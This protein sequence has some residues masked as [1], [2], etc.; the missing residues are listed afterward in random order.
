MEIFSKTPSKAVNPDEALAMGAAI[1]VK[2]TIQ[3]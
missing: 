1:Q 3:G 2:F